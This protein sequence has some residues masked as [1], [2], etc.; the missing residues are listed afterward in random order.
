MLCNPIK[1]LMPSS[2][3]SS[4]NTSTTKITSVID[5]SSFYPQ[6]CSFKKILN[7][8]FMA[9]AKIKGLVDICW[10]L[11]DMPFH[12]GMH[13]RVENVSY[14]TKSKVFSF[15]NSRK[16]PRTRKFKPLDP[17]YLF[18]LICTPN[19]LKK[20]NEYIAKKNSPVGFTCS[21]TTCSIL[22]SNTSCKISPL[23][24]LTPTITA[25]YLAINNYFNTQLIDK[26]TYVGNK[27]LFYSPGLFC[28]IILL[29]MIIH[30][31]AMAFI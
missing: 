26:T 1:N 7:D 25:G 3:L 31:I 22:R 13:L 20:L 18:G 6:A 27:Y 4:T 15:L 14:C 19:E 21:L 28:E 8:E 2:P 16:H 23:F 11:G 10:T 30:T 9:K 12:T 5:T 17:C 24:S 29:T